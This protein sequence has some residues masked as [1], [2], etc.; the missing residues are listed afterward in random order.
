MSIDKLQ[1][2]VTLYLGLIIM[3]I[4]LAIALGLSAIFINQSKTIRE[5]G[6]SVIAF[7]A[8]DSGI[9]KVL[10][11]RTDPTPLNGYSETMAN[12]A[13]FTISVLSSGEE[14]CTANY[15]CVK[16]IGEYKETRRAIEIT[17]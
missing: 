16:S 15:F 1:R 4:I 2:G 3:T 13:T 11:Q 17:Y 10:M 5:M 9:E 7:Y 12:G 14:G 6:N 8:A